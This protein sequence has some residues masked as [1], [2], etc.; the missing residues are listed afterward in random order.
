MPLGFFNPDERLLSVIEEE[1]LKRDVK[2]LRCVFLL[3]LEVFR[4]RFI[5]KYGKEVYDE[6]Y[7][8]Y[9]LKI[10]DEAKAKEARLLKGLKAL[11]FSE[12][13][14]KDLVT[15][16]RDELKQ[17]AEL[18]KAE[19]PDPTVCCGQKMELAPN[20]THLLCTICGKMKPLNGEQE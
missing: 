19:K 20:G 6:L 2:S 17:I 13:K 1:A 15:L 16:K 3:L 7:K 18:K 4:D 8:R 10:K 9:D 14:A 12:E 5:E 11:G